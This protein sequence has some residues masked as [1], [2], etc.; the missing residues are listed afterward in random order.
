M[1][2]LGDAEEVAGARVEV[3]V[4]GGGGGGENDS[5]DDVREDGDAGVLAGDDPGGFL[6]AREVVR[7]QGLVAGADADADD[8]GAED[9]EEEDAPED[10]ADGL[11]DVLAGVGSFTGGDGDHFGAA[12][13]EGGVDEGGPE[14]GE[15]AGVAG[16][17]VLFHRAFFP[18]AESAAVVV[19]GTAEPDNYTAEEET[20]DCYDLDG[21]EAELGFT[22]YGYGEDVQANDDDDNDCNPHSLVDLP[23]CIP[24]TDNDGCGRNFGT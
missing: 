12:V 11:G 3:C 15:A 1:A 8:E 19:W 5:V 14:T 24:E 10:A 13:G 16:A 7:G 21:C 20:K 17:D 2:E 4:S 6:G 9:V 22:V 18:V 23:F